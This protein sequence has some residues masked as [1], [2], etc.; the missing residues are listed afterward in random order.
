ME[1]CS[2]VPHRAIGPFISTGRIWQERRCPASKGQSG[3]G[4]FQHIDAMEATVGV[5][6]RLLNLTLIAFLTV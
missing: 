3:G 5:H 4:R 6:A 2:R 1:A